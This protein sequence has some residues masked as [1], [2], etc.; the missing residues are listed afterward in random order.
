M[1]ASGVY[2]TPIGET[3]TRISDCCQVILTKSSLKIMDI[4]ASVVF[5]LLRPERIR[6]LF[7]TG[8][9]H[10]CKMSES[11]LIV[12]RLCYNKLPPRSLRHPTTPFMASKRINLDM[13]THSKVV[14][15]TSQD[16]NVNR[17]SIVCTWS[18][19]L[20]KLEI[21]KKTTHQLKWKSQL[22]SCT[23]AEEHR[24]TRMFPIITLIGRLRG[25]AGKQLLPIEMYD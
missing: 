13:N 20:G 12:F 21:K 2:S 4:M 25:I 11:N 15:Y 8:R 1:T 19:P 10:V 16:L 24:W 14:S 22:E 23:L 5:N 6:L 3:Y 9:H 7:I 18:P 17:T